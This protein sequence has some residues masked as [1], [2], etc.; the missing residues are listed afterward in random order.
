MSKGERG[1]EVDVVWG[2]REHNMNND[3]EVIWIDCMHL[4][5]TFIFSQLQIYFSY[6]FISFESSRQSGGV[7]WMKN[8]TIKFSTLELSPMTF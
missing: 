3:D 7:F 5:E 1:K 6:Y 8:Q 4:S 2:T